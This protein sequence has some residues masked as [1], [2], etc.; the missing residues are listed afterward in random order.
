MSSIHT[1]L[2]GEDT[3]LLSE[4]YMSFE[5]SDKKVCGQLTAYLA[6]SAGV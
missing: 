5:L 1:V 3:Q 2:H 4:L 6:P